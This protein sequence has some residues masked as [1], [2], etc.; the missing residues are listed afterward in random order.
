MTFPPPAEILSIRKKRLALQREA[1]LLEQEEKGKLNLLIEHMVSHGIEILTDGEDQVELITTDE[2]NVESW[3]KL[4]D[5]IVKT[6]S[7]DL[8]Q[9]RVTASAVKKR[10]EDDQ[11]IP[12]V[13]P[14]EKHSLKFNV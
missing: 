9:K 8:L 5:Y 3:P 4:L 1:D 11:T 10:W 14:I 13:V 2:P 12:G 6:G 7:V